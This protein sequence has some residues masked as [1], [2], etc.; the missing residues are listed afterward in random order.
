VKTNFE[1]LFSRMLYNSPL[2]TV[3]GKIL[4]AVLVFI[5][6]YFAGHTWIS[7]L[8]PISGALVLLPSMAVAFLGSLLGLALAR[9]LDR[10][11]PE[12]W[13]YF[14]GFLIF[15]TFF[16][17][18][19]A[20][21]FNRISPLGVI[22]VGLNEEFWKAWPLLLLVWFAPTVVNGMR[23]GLIYGALGGFGFNIAEIGSY[24]L[25]VS[26]P[27]EGWEGLPNQLVRLGILG[28][29]NHVIWSAL[30]G[31]GIGLAM[32]TD[33]RRV[34]IFAPI[35]A[36]LLAVVTH[37]LQDTFAG[38]TIAIAFDIGYLVLRGQ[39]IMTLASEDP[40]T[41]AAMAQSGL[42]YTL[43]LEMLAI[44]VVNLIILARVVR[45]SG[46]WER[47]IIA[48]GLAAESFPVITPEEYAGVENEKRFRL[49][50]VPNY[51]VRVSRA[52]RNAQNE[53][54]MLK[55]YL[56][57]RNQAIEGDELVHY[58]RDKIDAL[59]QQS[60]LSQSM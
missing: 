54:A 48:D 59:R 1:T 21:Y 56:S 17:A 23:D 22:T 35:G 57:L 60:T 14:V 55:R 9:Y 25:R 31:A 47:K 37:T 46:D 11:K 52:I 13:Q 45:R 18:A 32:Q 28:I 40:E 2:H 42:P 39:D 15:A 34:K 27:E 24:V 36:Y 30:V 20:A 19:P 10:R 49:R 33:S 58:W 38:P 41:L 43:P 26:F 3:W 7:W 16:T 8:T 29:S 51:T 4:F 12:P 6:L 5:T 44:N 50:R 53:L